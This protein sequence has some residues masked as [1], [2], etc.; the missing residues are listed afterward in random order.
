MITITAK[1]PRGY[2]PRLRRAAFLEAGRF[3]RVT[4][5]EPLR[6][7]LVLGF[8]VLETRLAFGA[9]VRLDFTLR[10]RTVGAFRLR[11][12]ARLGLCA[13]ALL[14]LERRGAERFAVVL[15]GFWRAGAGAIC[16]ITSTIV[17]AETAAL[18]GEGSTQP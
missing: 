5:R 6:A 18:C 4:F 8:L 7:V 13:R 10:D 11:A 15:A 16:V 1:G 12:A 3:V 17:A 2:R 9:F 14:T